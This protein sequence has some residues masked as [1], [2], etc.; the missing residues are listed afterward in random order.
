MQ[1]YHQNELRFKDVYSRN[2]MP[3]LE[4]V[5]YVINL[6]TFES[7]ETHWIA[8]QVNVDNGS[9]SYDATLLD[10]FAVENIPKEKKS[11]KT[12]IS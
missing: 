10:S 7:I 8:L 12:K 3:K 1:K 9:V 11:W 5:A 2:N 4:Y 6:N